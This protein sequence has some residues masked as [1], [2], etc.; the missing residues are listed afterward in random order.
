MAFCSI[1]F[2]HKSI[3]RE[4]AEPPAFFTDLNLDQVIDAITARK[5]E[6]DLKPFFYTPLRDVETIRYR[7]EVMQ[8]LEDATLM[9]AIK[10]FA[11]K[12][13]IVRR[14]LAMVEKLDF[15]YHKKGW[16]LEAVLVYCDAVTELARNLSQAG[17]HSR[18]LQAFWEYLADYVRS[19]AFESLR[20]EA[21]Q[22]KEGLRSVKY[23]VIIKSGY[24]SV[25]RYGGEMDYTLEI[26]KVF[27]KFRQGEVKNY[28]VDIRE[29]TGMNHIEAKI[30]EF[31]ARLYP[32][33]FAALDRFCG[34]H[35]RFVDDT[36]RTFDREVQFYVAYLEFIADIRRKGLPFCYPQVSTTSREEFVREG[37]DL[38]LAYALLYTKTPVICNDFYLQGPER[39][40]VVSGPNQGGKTTFA[41]MFGQLHYLAGLGCPVPG[42]QASLFLPDQLFTQF[43]REED[44]RNLRGKLQ[45]D[46]MRIHDILVCA[47]PNSILILNEIFASTTLEDATFLSKQIMARIMALDALC[48]WVTFIDELSRLSE[49]SVSMVSTVD[50]QNPV[51]RTFKIVRKSADGLAYAFSIAQ[52]HRLTYEQIKERIKP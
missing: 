43:E 1:L 24:F 6:Y 4:T 40:I 36:I 38:A 16:F 8:D 23:S 21:Q 20:A 47:T 12:M 52:K 30:L 26:E 5:Q 33:P 9:T 39:I 46:L 14:Y 27:E 32:E 51:I 35:S 44:I 2:D 37:F 13:T 41:R 15:D 42:R 17:L 50:P 48:V 22:V 25:R 7:Q 10:A 45:D 31:V 19:A 3:Q 11:E 49:K 18:G 28:L 29:S 34:R